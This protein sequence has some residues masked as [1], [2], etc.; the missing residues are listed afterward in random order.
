MLTPGLG[1]SGYYQVTKYII[2]YTVEADTVIDLIQ[3]QLGSI[4]KN[5]IHVIYYTG[6]FFQFLTPVI[7]KVKFLLTAK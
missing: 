1:Y 4:D 6:G 5:G 7:V 2:W 3:E